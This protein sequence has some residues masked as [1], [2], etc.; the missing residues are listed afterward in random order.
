M[1]FAVLTPTTEI[2]PFDC[3]DADLNEFLHIDSKNYL[4][5][6]LAVT[7]LLESDTETV[8]FFSLL[9]DKI[10]VEDCPSNR[11]FALLFKNNM[12]EG[13]R[14]NSYPAMQIGRLGV[15]ESHKGQRYGTSIL[16]LIKGMIVNDIKTGCRYITVDA[17]IKS[18]D[19]YIKNGFKCFPEKEGVDNHTKP[20]YF[21]LISLVR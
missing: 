12:P 2:K 4:K 14:F 3:G 21:D 11:K 19:F 17:Y 5:E 8:A 9:N 16:D 10:A 7:Y 15:S 18:V 6:L 20:M 13:K 1:K